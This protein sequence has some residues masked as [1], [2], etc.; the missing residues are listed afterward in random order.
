MKRSFSIC[1]DGN[2]TDVKK[3]E[4]WGLFCFEGPIR[5]KLIVESNNYKYLDTIRAWCRGMAVVEAKPKDR[6]EEERFKAKAECLYQIYS[7]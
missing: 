1:S 7:M 2:M 3:E 6:D 5:V 4:R